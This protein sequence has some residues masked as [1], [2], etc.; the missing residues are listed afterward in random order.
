MSS[1][2]RDLGRWAFALLGPLTVTLLLG[3][4]DDP[5]QYLPST[6]YLPVVGVTAI[7]GGSRQ[8]TVAALCSILGAWWVVTTPKWSFR[9]SGV[10]QTLSLIG[11]AIVMLA[12]VRILAALV[13]QRD[14]INRLHSQWRRD[15]ATLGKLGE[16]NIIGFMAGVNDRIT[17]ANDYFL[18]MLG[19]AQTDLSAGTLKIPDVSPPEWHEEDAR[20]A[21]AFRADGVMPPWEKEYLHRDGHRVPIRLGGAKISDD[22]FRWI[23][24]VEDLT[25]RRRL[26]S[27]ERAARDISAELEGRALALRNIASAFVGTLTT[28][29][30]AGV[31]IEQALP[32]LNATALALSVIDQARN[33]LRLEAT[34]GYPVALA[35]YSTIDLSLPTAAAHAIRSRRPVFSD[36]SVQSHLELD[37]RWDAGEATPTSWV[38]LPLVDGDDVIG[39]LDFGWRER[40]PADTRRDYLE[41]LGDLVAGALSRSLRYI[42]AR[43]AGEVLQNAV[44]P[45]VPPTLSTVDIAVRYRAA[46]GNVG[47]DWWD[48]QAVSGDIVVVAVGDVVGRGLQAA[49]EMTKM[50]IATHSFAT[51]DPS[52]L[53][54]LDRLDRAARTWQRGIASTAVVATIQPDGAFRIGRAGH[55]YPMIRHDDATVTT[56]TGSAG[57]PLGVADANNFVAT[58]HHLSAGDIL[59]LY[60]DGLIER[61]NEPITHGMQRLEGC[62]GAWPGGDLDSLADHILAECL[63]GEAADDVCLLVARTKAAS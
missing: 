23:F 25:E 21:A 2:S 26:A 55:P 12:V 13:R 20:R 47:G 40:A 57:Y 58:M 14:R 49:Y 10:G 43:D 31:L 54:I 9:T 22:P 11:F 59:L 52:P 63:P 61:R 51:V 35:R 44:L 36:D 48:A 19:Y 50:R 62:L 33:D 39:I 32:A 18:T 34:H 38:T 3:L 45:M 27:A 7:W 53:V 5:R 30:I 37:H 60:T 6:W 16:A 17:Q 15:E 4:A 1:Q 29:Q 8:G 46:A 28:K 41:T 56:L 42:A 24:Y